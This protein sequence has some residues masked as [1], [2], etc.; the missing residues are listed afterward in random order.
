[1]NRCLK[2]DSV[3]VPGLVELLKLRT[4]WLDG[5][6]SA[7]A[8]PSIEYANKVLG[9]LQEKGITG[10]RIYPTPEGGVQLEAEDGTRYVELVI[11]EDLKAEGYFCES[12]SKWDG[13]FLLGDPVAAAEFMADVLL[14]D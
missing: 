5:E 2:S 7:I 6:G 11:G 13:V 8:L 9:D 3:W 10:V 4:G 14:G 12:R 1:M